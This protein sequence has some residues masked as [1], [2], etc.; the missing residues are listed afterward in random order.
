[1]PDFEFVGNPDLKYVT[2][3]RGNK[4]ENGRFYNEQPRKHPQVKEVVQ[5]KLAGN[6]QKEEKKN[7]DY[8]LTVL[9]NNQFFN[10]KEDMIVWLGHASFFIRLNGINIITDPCFYDMYFIKRLAN[11]PCKADEIVNI[12]YILLS[13]GHR[14]HFDIKS[15]KVLTKYNPKIKFLCP[16]KIGDLVKKHIGDF[17]IQE[18]GWYQQ[19]SMIRGVDVVCLPAI[20][21]NKRQLTDFN[22]QLWGSF[23]LE[24]NGFSIYFGG[25]S[26][27][28]THYKEINQHLG[29]PDVALLG[30]GAYSPQIIMQ[31]SHTSPEEAVEAC[32][33]L[34][35][36]HF[37][38]MHYATYDLSDEPISEPIRKVKA[39]AENGVLNANLLDL[40]IGEEWC[41]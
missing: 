19:F 39:L 30:I 6:P 25:D 7:D 4:F 2:D 32:N 18:A 15:L 31:S 35:A 22:N 13:H 28:G 40:K 12:D 41:W 36:K 16:L 38:P 26:S 17:E 21:W 27:M 37:I 23:W 8:R 1:M 9:A 34:G 11:L 20:H 29:S 3:Y 24:A 33:I 14:D 5:W 10:K